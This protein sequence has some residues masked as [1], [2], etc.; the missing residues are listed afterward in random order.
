ML[1]VV[2]ARMNVCQEGSDGIQFFPKLRFLA[3]EPS[4]SYD[5]REGFPRGL[6]H[7]NEIKGRRLAILL[8]TVEDLNRKGQCWVVDHGRITRDKLLV[9]LGLCWHLCMSSLV[10]HKLYDE[11]AGAA[12]DQPHS[13]VHATV[14]PHLSH[15]RIVCNSQLFKYQ[16]FQRRDSRIK[17]EP[18]EAQVLYKGTSRSGRCLTRGRRRSHAWCRSRGWH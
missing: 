8:A 10:R 15:R 11:A 12:A 14:L 3:R 9:L 18:A 6:A 5:F 17:R 7:H 16:R 4:S 2:E 13:I 1:H